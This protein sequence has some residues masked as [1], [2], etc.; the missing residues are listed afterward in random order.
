ML[1]RDLIPSRLGGRF[2]ASHIAIPGEGDVGDWVHYHRIAVQFLFCRTGWARLVYEDQGEPFMFEAGDLVLQPPRIRHRVL[3]SS[4]GFEVVE[5][6]SPA[7]HET[8]ADPDMA[9]PHSRFDPDRLFAGQRF[10]HSRAADARW[11]AIAQGWE[12]RET[13]LAAASAGLADAQ[14]LRP[15]GARRLD[16]PAPGGELCLGFFLAGSASLIARGEHALAAPDA[17]VIPPGEDWKLDQPSPDLQLL[18]VT[19][20][21]G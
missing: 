15:R 11:T 4:A 13:G 16:M 12:R 14:V 2:I 7:E 17:F 21:A 6:A 1:Y 20:P 18:L 19:S 3:E 8:L 5:I 9:L 10:L